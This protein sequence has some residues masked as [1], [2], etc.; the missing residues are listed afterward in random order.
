MAI[1]TKVINTTTKKFI[2]KEGTAGIYRRLKELAPEESYT[3]NVDPNATYREY[4][5]ATKDNDPDAVI[6]SSDDCQEYSVVRIIEKPQP[7][8]SSQE[9]SYT[10]EGEERSK[11]A[12]E[13]AKTVLEKAVPQSANREE[14]SNENFIVRFGKKWVPGFFKQG[15]A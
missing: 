1:N 10:W 11:G 9:P 12:L 6:L 13:K 7:Q 2:L 15:N 8:G 5:C 3:I 14:S 4:W